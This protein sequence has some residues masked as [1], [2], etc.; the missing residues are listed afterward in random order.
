MSLWS[1]SSLMFDFV[2]SVVPR[3]LVKS[4]SVTRM[5]EF[6]L[7]VCNSCYYKSFL[8]LVLDSSWSAALIQ[9]CELKV[10]LSPCST[11]IVIII[12][13]LSYSIFNYNNTGCSF[14]SCFKI[15]FSKM[16]VW[17]KCDCKFHFHFIYKSQSNF[18]ITD[19]K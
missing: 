16:H 4:N 12:S 6:L 8:S 19:K 3:K 13:R 18:S 17:W 5:L 11:C 1:I 9:M 15:I 10:W 2:E 14:L 7:P